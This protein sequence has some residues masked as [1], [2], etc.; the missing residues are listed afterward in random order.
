MIDAIASCEKRLVIVKGP[1]R[2]GK[3]EALVRRC[4]R[5]V[6]DGVE[7]SKILAVTTSSFAAQAFRR[8][9]RHALGESA[10]GVATLTALETCTRVLG[11]PEARTA[12]GR[13]PRLLNDA[14]YKFLLED[15]KALGL[16]PRRLRPALDRL[17]AKMAALE[18]LDEGDPGDQTLLA[19]I[20]RTMTLREAMLAAEAPR[21]CALHLQSP[22]GGHARASYEFV[23]C[24]DS[25]NLS[26]AE[27]TCL[28]LLADTQTVFAG[29]EEGQTAPA[30]AEEAA[31]FE[32]PNTH[33]NA[34]IAAFANALRAH[35]N[36]SP[37]AATHVP[38]S[39]DSA[40]EGVAVVK[41]GT[42]EEELEG[43]AK[44]VRATVDAGDA[45][46][47]R[48]CVAV[49]N[50]R[51]ALSMEK[52]LKRRGFATSSS[53]VLSPF[54]GDPRESARAKALVAYTKLNLL[55]DP[56][57]PVAWRSWCGFDHPSANSAA[58]AALQDFAEAQGASL[59][60]AL[61]AAAR[62]GAAFEGA[63]A[64]AERWR[65]GQ[66]FLAR[67]GGRR[68]FGVMRVIG[69]EGLPEFG[70]IE[71]MLEGDE[72]AAGV[73]ALQ[74][75]QI[76]SPSFPENVHVLNIATLDALAGTEFD[77]LF[78]VSA[79]NGLVP[80]RAALADPDEGQR[81]AALDAERRTFCNGVSK[82]THRL[83]VSYFASAPLAL[84]ERDHLDVSRV[85]GADPDKTAVVR[86]SM[87][88]AEAGD[89]CPGTIGGQAL[90]AE[91]GLA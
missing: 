69:A 47:G 89:A 10:D 88:L 3:T 76:S 64:L 9:L 49:P 27:R 59:V 22:S 29:D 26:V 15:L 87:F 83:V 5:L 4:V 6:E 36:A 42:P 25:Q 65:A 53:G 52:A 90:L 56:R 13:I 57:D 38:S 19:Q 23:L 58:W 45:H 51:W 85:R 48:T 81:E 12:T 24:D 32:L 16:P 31:T 79:V 70:E 1:A 39:G 77:N 61:E 55:A 46:E 78:V 66:D 2:S 63:D 41:W 14:E 8:R 17:F 62:D 43:V 73:L 86:P 30:D 50:K 68:G 67:S 75:A 40:G 74:R 28:R 37:S 91:R 54:G 80:G 33:G 72:D 44:L 11:S 84:A 71:R 18:P 35:G 7:P 82:A 34:A 60:D 20:E 21:L